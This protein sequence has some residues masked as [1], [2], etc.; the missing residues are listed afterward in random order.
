MYLG[1]HAWCINLK[2]NEIKQARQ[3][4]KKKKKK[5]KW[6]TKK[7]TTTVKTNTDTVYKGSIQQ[8][9]K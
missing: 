3:K 8:M 7:T 6:K 2:E 4:K 1:P 9:I 5:K